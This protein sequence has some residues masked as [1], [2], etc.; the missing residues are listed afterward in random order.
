LQFECVEPWNRWRQHFDGVLLAGAFA[1]L[2]KGL[3]PLGTYVPAAVEL[4]WQPGGPIW[5]LGEDMQK[6]A[7][8]HSHYNQL[9]G[10]VGR[11]SYRGETVDFDGVG[12]RDH[13]R[14]PRD[15]RKFGWHCWHHGV[16]PG[17][18]G[19][20]VIDAVA[21]GGNHMRRA[22]VREAG[23]LTE[24]EIVES[25]ALR[26]REDGYRDYE[27]QL[28]GHAPIAAHV[29][30]N[31]PMGFALDNEITYGYDPAIST[32]TLFEGFTRFTWEGEAGYGLT[33]RSLRHRSL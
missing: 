9:G 27:I 24:A 21:D 11:V 8:G 7:W 31:N 32:H 28:G 13:T 6:Q 29:L 30:H 14:G 33:E 25:G 15:F 12:I 10:L 16:F 22:I 3:L 23:E 19:F 26:S 17:G 20:M 2:D 4:E 5:N 1:E 18:R